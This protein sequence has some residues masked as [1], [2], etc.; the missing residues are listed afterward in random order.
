MNLYASYDDKDTI[1]HRLQTHISILEQQQQHSNG[2]FSYEE[3]PSIND[4]YSIDKNPNEDFVAL[5]KLLQKREYELDQLREQLKE[6]Q[7][8]ADEKLHR[9]IEQSNDAEKQL[10]IVECERNDLRQQLQHLQ[11]ENDLIKSYMNRL[12]SE[13]EYQKLRQSHQILEDQLKQSNQTVIE[14]R[15]EKN[16]LKKQLITYERTIN[17]QQQKI[18][19]HESSSDK[20]LL[21]AKCLTMDERVETEKKF[22]Q[23]N[24]TIQQL[25][26]KLNEEKLLRKHDQYLN[27]IN[28]RT[29][30]SLSNEIAKKEQTIKETTNLLRQNR[31]ELDELRMRF[32][33]S[34]QEQIC[35][36]ERLLANDQ[37]SMTLQRVHATVEK[38][39]LV[40]DFSFEM[41]NNESVS[42]PD[43]LMLQLSTHKPKS[44]SI[45]SS[46]NNIKK[47]ELCDVEK[48][49]SKLDHIIDRL[50]SIRSE[51]IARQFEN[52]LESNVPCRLQ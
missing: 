3:T 8:E 17:E 22:K 28:T 25:N 39:F 13:I 15:K 37:F 29:L 4:H 10:S 18:Q 27:E 21:N 46:I 24:Q 11:D 44:D 6:F 20:T 12:P 48:L 49:E 32:L 23:L 38:L 50:L 47:I 45:N 41:L 40:L 16:H 1:I 43:V 26:E 19:S 9:T 30:Q 5:E 35:L 36:N 52:D 31:Q 51:L 2:Y 7:Q 42:S 33:V 14:S 34:E